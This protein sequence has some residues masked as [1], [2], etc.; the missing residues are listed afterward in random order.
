MDLLVGAY[1][2]NIAFIEKLVNGET[3]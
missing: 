2:Q 3:K 1:L